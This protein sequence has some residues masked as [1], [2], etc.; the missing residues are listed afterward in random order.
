M[1]AWSIRLARRDD[2]AALPAIERSA[3]ELLAGYPGIEGIDP[4]QVTSADRYRAL[5]AKGH[6][7]V[8][9][10]G[11]RVVGF[12]VTEPC[13][14]ELHIREISVTTQWQR[15]GIGAIMIRACGID[16][17]NAGFSALTLTTFRDVPWNAPFYARL[18]FV[19]VAEPEEH[20][21]LSS[22]LENEACAG[23]KPAQRVA[24]IRFLG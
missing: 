8:A 2:A 13:G 16:A 10:V 5:I 11:D 17:G 6:S 24:M 18:G 4:K 23:L 15:Q 20:L 3:A 9:T 1:T 22:E 19:E 7:L 14:R 12:L 21:R